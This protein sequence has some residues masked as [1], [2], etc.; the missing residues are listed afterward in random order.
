VRRSTTLSAV[1][2]AAG[3]FLLSGC[4]S[5]QSAQTATQDSAIVGVNTRSADGQ[6]AVRDAHVR[7]AREYQ[8]GTNAPLVLRL[9]NESTQLVTL[10][11]V[12]AERGSVV[13]VSKVA[14]TTA[15]PT[16][17]PPTPSANPSASASPNGSRRPSASASA[18]APTSAAPTTPPA[19]GSPNISIPIP[20]QSFVVLV[21][22]ESDRWLA[23][24]KLAE[25]VTSG[26][27][28]TVTLTF[29]YADGST[30]RVTDLRM[31]VGVPLSPGPRAIP[32]GAG[33][34]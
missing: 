32:S 3:M 22:D 20:P 23:V 26:D 2:L 7:F 1:V 28:V 30:T 11:G 16:T 34:H 24:D 10:T 12:T 14:P 5:G 15:P 19:L 27:A 8:A 33:E 18:P 31:P 13:V 25:P 4:G 6:I 9:F 17:A 29:T 21:P